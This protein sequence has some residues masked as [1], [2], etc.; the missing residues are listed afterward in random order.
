[1]TLHR[2][3]L[4]CAGVFAL[5]WIKAAQAHRGHQTLSLVDV[6][7]RG[8]VR[9]THTL[10]AHDTEPELVRL[11]P[12]ANPSVDDPDALQALLDHLAGG[13]TVN[14]SRAELLS[15]NLGSDMLTFVHRA[16]IALAGKGLPQRFTIDYRLF[17]G[18]YSAPVGL[19]Q[20]RY[21]GATKSL[22]CVPGSVPQSVDF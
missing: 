16:R 11:A 7:A 3:R 21:R 20:V 9:I 22:Q 12:A 1:M 5:A 18:S 8:E 15:Y 14:G 17:A 2:R 13:F 6:D 19:V 4:L 10:T